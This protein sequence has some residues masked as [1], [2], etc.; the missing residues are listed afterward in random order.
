MPTGTNWKFIIV[1]L[2][3]FSMLACNATT[4][5]PLTDLQQNLQQDSKSSPQPDSQPN[6]QPQ[7]SSDPGINYNL[8]SPLGT[9]T[10]WLRDWSTALPFI[11]IFHGARYFSETTWVTPDNVSYDEQGWPTDLKGGEAQAIMLTSFRK[12]HAPS[13]SYTVLYDGKG[14]ISY[15]GSGKLVTR[16]PG[17]DIVL[18]QPDT[19]HG[20]FSLSIKR[21]TS[22]NHIRNIRVLLPGGICEGVITQRVD[23]AS[24]CDAGKYMS[25]EKH[26]DELLFNPDYL[27]F[28]KDFK[29]VRFMDMMDTNNSKAREWSDWARVD[30]AVWS[31]GMGRTGVPVEVMV[32]LANTINADPWFTMPHLASDDYMRRFA[33][34]VK[35]KLKPGLKVYIEYTNEAWNSIFTQNVYMV[36]KGT[37]A[38]NNDSMNKWYKGWAYFG[39]RTK[40]MAQIWEDEFGG[41]ERLVR[42][43]GSQASRLSVSNTPLEY[44]DVANYID[45]LAIAPY[46]SVEGDVDVL[47][48]VSDV[49]DVFVLMN[50]GYQWNIDRVI[51]SQKI[52]KKHNIDLIAYE[53]GQHLVV[54]N[55]ENTDSHPNPFLYA[56]NRDPRMGELYTRF[57][58]DWKTNGG[59][60]F[61][62]FTSPGRWSKH[63]SWGIKEYL[64]QPASETPKYNAVL[65]FIKDNPRWW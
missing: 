27:N 41:T 25:F 63:G 45:A 57:L 15:G 28:M 20:F 19:Q 14:K 16:S 65:D 47:R 43:L 40:Q 7:P 1:L 6:P 39:L 38:I 11:N 10:Q 2:I 59:Q 54:Y 5:N 30:D 46:F 17:R 56:A 18:V 34:V 24:S 53:G 50:Q 3:L 61:A 22:G 58:L 48:Q 29:S 49:D 23:S 31:G 64:T 51:A 8:N 55:T 12:D 44:Q 21:T 62:Q 42:V 37:T 52:A 60:M 33:A 36:E 35:E 9:N 4:V 13:G 32:K 26:H